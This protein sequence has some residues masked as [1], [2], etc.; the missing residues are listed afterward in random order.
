M[1]SY[2]IDSSK[3]L[4][5]PYPS[6]EENLSTDVCI[7]GGG[8]A[9]LTSAYLLSRRGL[10]TI[11]LE[12]DSICAHTSRTYHTAKLLALTIYFITIFFN[13]MIIQQ[14]KVI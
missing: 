2:W 9:G 1:S 8:L 3:N 6:L 11:I 14:R 12:K 4:Y 5:T 13:L 7:I 10:S